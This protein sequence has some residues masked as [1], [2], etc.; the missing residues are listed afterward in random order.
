MTQGKYRRLHRIANCASR[1]PGCINT[2]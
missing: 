1:M 2:R